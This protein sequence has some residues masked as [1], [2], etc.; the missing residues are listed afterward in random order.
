M[1]RAMPRET[2]VM[3]ASKPLRLRGR[4][5]PL[6]VTLPPDLV[7]QIDAL[8]AIEHRSRTSMLEMLVRAGLRD[9]RKDEAA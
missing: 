1:V 2:P 9:H 3:V 5:Q 8:A 7:E 6:A 4:R